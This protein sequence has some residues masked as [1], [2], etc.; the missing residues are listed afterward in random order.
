MGGKVYIKQSGAKKCQPPYEK[1]SYY[2]AHS[3]GGSCEFTYHTFKY[4]WY[5]LLQ[6]IKIEIIDYYL[7]IE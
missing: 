2:C 7:K 3:E 4:S 5:V 1:L 6:N